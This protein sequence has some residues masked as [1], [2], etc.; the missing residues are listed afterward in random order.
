MPP[1]CTVEAS[2][3]RGVCIVRLVGEVDLSNVALIESQMASA[4]TGVQRAVID[5]AALEYVDSS[6]LGMLERFARKIAVQLVVPDD[7]VIS[8][9]LAVTGLDQIVPVFTSCDDA[10]GAEPPHA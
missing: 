9:T 3:D 2:H 8:R 6:G 4:L 10:L 7:A 1:L 5:L